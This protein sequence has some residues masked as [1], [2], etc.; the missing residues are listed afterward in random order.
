M[1]F[2]ARLFGRRA[3]A[4]RAEGQ[5]FASMNDP[6]FLEFIRSGAGGGSRAA[7]EV[8][9]VYRCVS[10]ISSAIAMLPLRLVE[11][12]PDGVT[13]GVAVDHPLHDVLM[14]D[15][16]AA[17]SA[18]VFKHL[19]QMRLLTRGN[20]YARIVRTGTRVA[21]LIPIDP[22]AVEVEQ[23]ADGTLSYK[24]TT[25]GGVV[26]LAQADVLHLFVMSTDGISGLSPVKLAEEAIGLSQAASQSLSRIY[27]TG[28]SAGGVLSHPHKLSKEAKTSLKAALQDYSGAENAG[29]WMVLDEGMKAEALS[30]TAR[31]SQTL[32]TTRHQVEDIARFF[33]VPRPLMGLDDTSW[34]SGVEQLAILFVR[35][36][37]APYFV[38]WEQG[39]RRSLLTRDEKRRFTVDFDERELLRGSM[40]D[41]AEFFAKALGAGGG[42]GWKTQNEIRDLAGDPH[43][44]DGNRLPQ[45]QNSAGANN[46]PAQTP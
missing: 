35:F 4:P 20:A 43:H 41:Q 23:K 44:P 15:P 5:A 40:K 28:V 39:M 29:R 16:N 8:S 11:V 46:V 37:L 26:T 32:E 25:K 13:G 3:A 45:P 33:G 30:H 10:L 14:L 21:A 7:L 42:Y 12:R 18:F 36:A 24:V 19:M 17:Q 31:D 27:K 2:L 1:S 38:A 9:A 6:D 22:D 34:G